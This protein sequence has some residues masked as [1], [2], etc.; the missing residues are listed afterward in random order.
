VLSS[1]F[2]ACPGHLL[3]ECVPWSSHVSFP[4]T[5]SLGACSHGH[6]LNLL[7]TAEFELHYDDSQLLILNELLYQN[8]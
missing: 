4:E 6:G 3:G 5:L 7:E 1:S 8:P 2:H